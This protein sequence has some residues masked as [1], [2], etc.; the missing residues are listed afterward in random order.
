MAHPLGT[1]L[2]RWSSHDRGFHREGQY[3]CRTIRRPARTRPPLTVEGR[4][5]QALGFDPPRDLPFYRPTDDSPSVSI[6]R[7]LPLLP[8]LRPTHLSDRMYPVD[9]R[10][11]SWRPLLEMAV[12]DRPQ[13]LVGELVGHA[14][15]ADLG[16]V[17]QTR[18]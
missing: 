15:R 4:L 7:V 12:R 1:H 10:T 2:V 17:G 16:D 6:D 3:L 8:D 14:D 13:L 11:V 18:P 9:I 5:A